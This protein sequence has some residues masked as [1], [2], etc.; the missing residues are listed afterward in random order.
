MSEDLIFKVDEE[1]N[2]QLPTENTNRQGD[3]TY[4]DQKE[5][6]RSITLS[7]DSLQQIQA[8]VV[9]LKPKIVE[10]GYSGNYNSN[11]DPNARHITYELGQLDPSPEKSKISSIHID[12]KHTSFLNGWE[13][14]QQLVNQRKRNSLIDMTFEPLN[15]SNKTKKRDQRSQMQHINSNSATRL[16]TQA[17]NTQGNQE[18]LKVK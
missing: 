18:N 12:Y 6:A 17:L 14:Q 3:E 10:S 1:A 9:H 4:Y 8:Q 5:P 16:Q 2:T 15:F 11:M 13:S 7:Q